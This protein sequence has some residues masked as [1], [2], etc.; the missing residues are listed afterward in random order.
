[1]DENQDNN[2][3]AND[4]MGQ[5]PLFEFNPQAGPPEAQAHIDEQEQER[6]LGNDDVPFDVESIE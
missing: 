6:H 3:G 5:A 4:I 1:M 2:Q